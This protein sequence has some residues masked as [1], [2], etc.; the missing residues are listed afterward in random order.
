MKI[1]PE[2]ARKIV[3]R[4]EKNGFIFIHQ[5]GSHRYYLKQESSK[6]FLTSVPMHP[7]DLSVGTIQ[8]II[9]QSGLQ[10][11]DFYK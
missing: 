9:R 6:R 11:E 4:L 3:K 7:G 10:R 2:P 1:K 8:A 5:K